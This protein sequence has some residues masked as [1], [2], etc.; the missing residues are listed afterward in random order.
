MDQIHEYLNR[1]SVLGGQKMEGVVIKPLNYDQY[2]KDKKVL[3]AKFVSEAYKEVHSASWKEQNPNKND[4]ITELVLT[5]K[6]PARWNKAI[7]HLKEAG[8]LEDSPRD[9]GKLLKEVNVDI[10]KECEEEIKEK[11]FNWA[12]KDLSRLLISG[13]PQYYKDLLGES[14]FTPGKETENV[15]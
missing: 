13:F 9:I 11:L 8:E 15:K 10:L 2:G 14:A 3:M 12:W 6:T 4:I 1:V 7:Q 5:Y